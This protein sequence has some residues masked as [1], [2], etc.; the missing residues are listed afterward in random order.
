M[1]TDCQTFFKKLW[2]S[3]LQ[4]ESLD[5]ELAGTNFSALSPDYQSSG[6]VPPATVV[7]FEKRPQ[8]KF[9]SFGS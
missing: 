5:L 4:P 3:E 2:L 1:I 9:G 7:P 8:S 6:P